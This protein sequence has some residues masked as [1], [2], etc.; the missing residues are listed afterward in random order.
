MLISIAL[1]LDQVFVPLLSVS[2]Q[3]WKRLPR[4]EFEMAVSRDS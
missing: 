1:A 2:K 4:E 3:M